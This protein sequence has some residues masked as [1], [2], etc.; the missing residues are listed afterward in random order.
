MMRFYTMVVEEKKMKLL[1]AEDDLKL[2]ALVKNL[3][4]LSGFEVEWV[5]DG[6][7]TLDFIEEAA[8]SSYDVIILDWMLP[9]LSGIEICRLLRNPRKYN[10]QGGIIFLTARDGT[11]DCVT[12]LESG[13]DDYLVKPFENKELIARVNA[14]GRRK[15]RPFVDD[16]YTKAGLEMNSKT[17]TVSFD[18]KNLKLSRR[19]FELFRLLFVNCGQI[20]LRE[21]IMDKVWID[22]PDISPA[23]LDAYIYILRRK[24][25]KL[26]DRVQIRLV[27]GIGYV[28]EIEE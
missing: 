27:K 13:A 7:E 21:T 20:I 26:S 22:N 14:L 2:G 3:L 8:A 11:D 18:G 1:L 23:S 28:L 15:G 12:G 16:I 19:E 17:G 9:E 6:K 10:Y 24:I 4:E 25:G 5:K